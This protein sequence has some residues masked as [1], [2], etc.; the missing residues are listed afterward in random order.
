MYHQHLK[1]IVLKNEGLVLELS[2]M[3]EYYDVQINDFEKELTLIEEENKK[4][5]R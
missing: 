3:K 1:S 5:N 2:Q 4:K